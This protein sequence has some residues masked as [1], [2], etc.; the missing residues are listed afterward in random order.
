M[1]AREF[2]GI[3]HNAWDNPLIE[4]KSDCYTGD[5]QDPWQPYKQPGAGR[6]EPQESKE[7]RSEGST[8]VT[9]TSGYARWAVRVLEPS[10]GTEHFEFVQ[11]NWA[12]PFWQV[13]SETKI[14]SEV[15]RNDPDEKDA[16]TPPDP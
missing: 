10:E 8:F 12:I 11:V 6:I 13:T 7:W 14:Y 5:W 3:I 9:G 2:H 4:V 16:F 1:A 15:W